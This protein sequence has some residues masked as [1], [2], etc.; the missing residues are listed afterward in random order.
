MRNLRVG[1]RIFITSS[2]SEEIYV[3]AAMNVLGIGMERSGESR[4]KPSARVKSITG[5]FRKVP[6][7]KLK[8]ASA[9]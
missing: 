6:L 2:D 3:F 5:P 9:I 4:G 7:G 1:D 8:M